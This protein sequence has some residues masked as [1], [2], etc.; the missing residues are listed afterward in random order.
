MQLNWN[1]AII[2]NFVTSQH[3]STIIRCKT[4]TNLGAQWSLYDLHCTRYLLAMLFFTHLQLPSSLR[5]FRNILIFKAGVQICQQWSLQAFTKHSLLTQFRG[6]CISACA[7]CVKLGM[8]N[9]CNNRT[10]ITPTSCHIPHLRT[11]L[12]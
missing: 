1:L 10:T 7:D 9:A 12:R 11:F 8:P 6:P 4:R 2:F 5:G 3:I